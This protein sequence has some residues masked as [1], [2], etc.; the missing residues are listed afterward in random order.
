LT[1]VLREIDVGALF[2]AGICSDVDLD[3]TGDPHD[4]AMSGNGV[5]PR[6]RPI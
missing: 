3:A 2:S 1:A 6:L 4:D 5:I